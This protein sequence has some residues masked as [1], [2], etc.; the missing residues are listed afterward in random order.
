MNT[1]Q[2]VALRADEANPSGRTARVSQP[3]PPGRDLEAQPLSSEV[4]AGASDRLHP[5][6]WRLETGRTTMAELVEWQHVQRGDVVKMNRPNARWLMVHN[7]DQ[8]WEPE[9]THFDF[10]DVDGSHSHGSRPK[11]E[12]IRDPRPSPK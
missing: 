1:G 3:D 7:I 2:V 8:Q 11:G 10:V 4:A 5:S 12:V 6:L 9:L